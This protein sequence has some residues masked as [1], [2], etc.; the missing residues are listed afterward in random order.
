MELGN[1]ILSEVT[2]TQKGMHGMYSSVILA[3]KSAEYPGYSPQN[4]KRLTS[5]RA[6]VRTPQSHLRER[7]KQSWGWGGKGGT[8]VKM[9][10]GRGRR[11]HDQV[12]GGG[13]GLK[14]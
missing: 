12:L 6:Q 2:Q 13:K 1:I 9:G 14:P 10:T 8:W 11:E 5:Q 4:T 3:K 7:R